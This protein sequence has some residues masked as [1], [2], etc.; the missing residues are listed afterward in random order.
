MFEDVGVEF[1]WFSEPFFSRAPFDNGSNN[2][3]CGQDSESF[4]GSTNGSLVEDEAKTASLHSI[5]S[6][7]F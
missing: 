7:R 3:L 1:D 4:D 6:V 2:G 5:S